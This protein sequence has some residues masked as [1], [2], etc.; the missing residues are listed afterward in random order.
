MRPTEPEKIEES[1]AISEGATIKKP[2]ER[3]V[4]SQ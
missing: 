4:P 1:F 3:E 2:T